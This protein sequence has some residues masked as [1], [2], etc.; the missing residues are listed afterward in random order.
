M[1]RLVVAAGVMLAAVLGWPARGEVVIGVAGPMTGPI[2][3]FGE[4]YLRAT[5]MAVEIS[6]LAAA[7]SARSS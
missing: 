2:A 4:Q 5:G 3:W 1:R 6:M 7:F